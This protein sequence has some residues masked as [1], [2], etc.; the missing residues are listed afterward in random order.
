MKTVGMNQIAEQLNV[1]RN[2]VSKVMNGRGI[3]AE[4]TRKKIIKAAIEMGYSKL[5]EH[6][7]RE[8]E[9]KQ[10]PKNILVLATS[11]DFSSFW[12]KMIKGITTE[13]ASHDYDCFYNF[14]TFEQEEDF[15]MPELIKNAELAGIIIMN[16]YNKKAILEIA[17]MG[18]P[19]VYYD[20]PLGVNCVHAKADVVM[21]EGRESV[22]EITKSL[23]DEGNHQLGF[24][25]D[26]SYCKSI[27]ER[28]SGFVMAHECM[29][30]PIQKKYCFTAKE[31]G[32]FYFG[33]EVECAVQGLIQGQEV[34]PDGLVCANDAIAYKVINELKQNGYSVP[35]DIKVSGFDDIDLTIS[36]E[37]KLT[38]VGVCIEEIGMKLAQQLVWR[39]QNPKRNYE[40]VKIYGD[41]HLRESTRI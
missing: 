13:L 16:M 28:W 36:E 6:L 1:S 29:Q 19:A 4:K 37:K 12:G 25:G 11:P 24:I 3:V 20:L 40:T 39:I 34:L 15:V 18:I 7:L 33:N 30:I 38:S 26:A 5:P 2:T 9:R 32:H 35:K 23:L 14:L 21:V 8:Y 31:R 27:E 41:V 17:D 22:F 10:C